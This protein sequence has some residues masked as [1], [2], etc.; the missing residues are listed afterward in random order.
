ML[1]WECHFS[2]M[3]SR[4]TK[5]TSPSISISP[6]RTCNALIWGSR[7]TGKTKII[8]INRISMIGFRY[9]TR[10]PLFRNHLRDS[11]PSNCWQRTNHTK[12]DF[13]CSILFKIH[14]MDLK[15]ERT[16]TAIPP[17]RATAKLTSSLLMIATTLR[18]TFQ[19]ENL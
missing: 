10:I 4:T 11:I 18:S 6:S 2:T 9:S 5:T 1:P 13:K 8:T 17:L 12:I 7:G 3:N 16:V 19:M 14:W 15:P